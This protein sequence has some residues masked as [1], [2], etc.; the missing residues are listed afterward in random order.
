MKGCE[1]KSLNYKFGPNWDSCECCGHTPMWHYAHFNRNILNPIQRY[2][3]LRLALCVV[4][5][6][7]LVK[8]WIFKVIRLDFFG[9]EHIQL[10]H[11]RKRPNTNSKP[12]TITARA[13]SGKG[14]RPF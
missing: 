6:C 3:L 11:T 2:V 7:A 8:R 14:A 4:I 9:R 12:H 5:V 1:C 13:T 10:P